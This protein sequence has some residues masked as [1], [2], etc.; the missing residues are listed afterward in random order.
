MTFTIIPLSCVQDVGHVTEPVCVAELM[1]QR[2]GKL[3]VRGRASP[4]RV[5]AEREP[6]DGVLLP[7]AALAT[8]LPCGVDA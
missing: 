2:R 5:A 4:M 7:S 1:Q 3:Q 8:S 6:S